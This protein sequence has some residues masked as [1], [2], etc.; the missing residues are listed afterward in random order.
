MIK[1]CFSATKCAC[2]SKKSTCL[3][4]QDYRYNLDESIT[5]SSFELQVSNP[6][7]LLNSNNGSSK[8]DLFN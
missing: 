4:Y 6:A 3:T 8:K 2:C 7:N 5:G 1:S